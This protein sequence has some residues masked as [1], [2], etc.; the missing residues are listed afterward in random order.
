MTGTELAAHTGAVRALAARWLP[1]FGDGD[2]VCSPA[3]LWLALGAVASGARGGTA[4]ELRNVLGVDGEAAAGAVTAGGRWLRRTEGVA[5]ATGVWSGVPVLD[6]FR[7]GLPDVGFGPLAGAGGAQREIDSW[8][9]ESTGG[10]IDRLPL[11]LDGSED[12][13]LVNALALKA[14]WLGAFPAAGTRDKP[15]TD[16]NGDSALVPTMHR[17]IPAT[18]AWRVGGATVVELPCQGAGSAGPAGAAGGDEGRAG[19]EGS[20]VRVRFVLGAEGDDPAGAPAAAWAEAGRREALRA[21]GV[22]LALPRFSLRARTDVYGQLPALGVSRAVRPGA[23]FSGLSPEE[24]CISKVVQEALVEVAEQG[25]EA[26][27]VTTVAMTRSGAPPRPKVI[28]EIAFDRPFGVVVLD[29]S[30]EVPLFVGR[31]SSAPRSP[32]RAGGSA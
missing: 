4:E 30:G 1:C 22:E 13:V 32:A 19:A 10:R 8:V 6:G 12:L 15:F 27:A 16:R 20:A 7:Q 29:A 17:R 3:G 24:L 31:Q 26:A 21:D 25:V 23:D 14:S 9:E 5:V 2:F 18:W 28:E 11:A